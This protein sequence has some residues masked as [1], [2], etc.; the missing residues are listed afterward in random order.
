MDG[1]GIV[2]AKMIS[3]QG[4]RWLRAKVLKE[5]CGE[6][7]PGEAWM[8]PVNSSPSFCFPGYYF[9]LDLPVCKGLLEVLEGPMNTQIWR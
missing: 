5:T 7:K 4:S 6:G 3:E 2:V 8:L 1:K 9:T